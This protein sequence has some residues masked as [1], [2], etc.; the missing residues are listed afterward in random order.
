M[1]R[2]I[3]APIAVC[4]L[5]AFGAAPPP[6]AAGDSPYAGVW[7][8]TALFNT[9]EATFWLLKI[10]KRGRTV[11][12]AHGLKYRRE[13]TAIDVSETR[14]DRLRADAK[15][16]RCRLT[17]SNGAVFHLV[18]YPG[19]KKGVMAGSL[20]ANVSDFIRVRM[21]KTEDDEIDGEKAVRNFDGA[22]NFQAALGQKSEEKKIA[23]LQSLLEQHEDDPIAYVAGQYLITL[24]AARGAPSK[25][26]EKPARLLA[27][28][29]GRYGHEFTIGANLDVGGV[30]T[31]HEKT[32]ALGLTYAKRA[33]DLVTDAD[34]KP[35]ALS[36]YL[37]Y[38]AALEKNG[39]AEAVK[40]VVA[41]MDRAAADLVEEAEDDGERFQSTHLASAM[42]LGSPSGGVQD[43]GLKY[44]AD[45][46]KQ[47]KEK[48]PD[49]KKL[50]VL[51]LLG[52]GLSKRPGKDEEA[53]KVFARIEAIESELDSKFDKQNVDFEVE[54]FGKRKGKSQRVVLV[55]LFT[56]AHAPRCVASS[57]AFDAALKTFSAKEVVLLQY[58]L[59]LPRPSP[60]ANADS[61]ARALS[62]GD[63]IEDT[64]ALFIDGK[65]MPM[66]AGAKTLAE[67]RY[68]RL[69]ELLIRAVEEEAGAELGLS[70]S[71][72]GEKIE[73][74]AKVAG[75]EKTGKK[76]RLRVALVEEVARYN[77]LNGQ[78]LHRHVVR[79]LAA[80][81]D[82]EGGG[83]AGVPMEEKAGAYVVTID[84]AE[85][86][87]SHEAYL[88]RVAAKSGSFPLG[89]PM[90]LK[91]LKVAA[92]IQDDDTKQVYQAAQADVPPAKEKK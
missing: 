8:V 14:A 56:G 19:K 62:Y 28:Q 85:V 66:T 53:K 3:L 55:E 88:K 7:K 74:V 9:N 34:P 64:P 6:P 32:R 41:K 24:L 89:R 31:N 46:E 81:P 11:R 60:L 35:L 13:R 75:L 29:A 87:K 68:A 48:D 76:V 84:L 50:M 36:A 25:E 70:T 80:P 82:V 20:R 79:A 38:A 54:E 18:A 33:A 61:E 83:A 10:D 40:R 15:T 1:Q 22:D 73:V 86:R 77:G 26:F 4:A 2:L 72:K 5:A 57:V 17:M 44:A 43:L 71:R 63:E 49:S 78:R 27:E 91:R 21:E 12:V 45:L 47:L 92:F 90:Q 58:H 42:L 39:K 16:L 51:Y 67:K 30:L 69:R 65:L 23:G 37:G 59:N 52:D